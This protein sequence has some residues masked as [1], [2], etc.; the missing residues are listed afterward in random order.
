VQFLSTVKEKVV[1]S[2]RSVLPLCEETPIP[3]SD[4][5][6]ARQMVA[7]VLTVWCGH[8]DDS[9]L[10][11]GR[12]GSD[13]DGFRICAMFEQLAQQNYIATCRPEAVVLYVPHDP[14]NLAV[15]VFLP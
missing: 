4:T 14:I 11:E 12:S 1:R 6:K 3:V 10:P 2:I 5:S 15:F 9:S 13:K 8:N 7:D